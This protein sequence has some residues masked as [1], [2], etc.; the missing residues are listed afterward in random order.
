MHSVHSI[1]LLCTLLLTAL[2]NARRDDRTHGSAFPRRS[3]PLWG[4]TLSLLSL[5][6]VETLK[7]IG[8]FTHGQ[9]SFER[10]H[11][12]SAVAQQHHH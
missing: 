1:V 10:S 2:Q 5:Q 9:L 6:T 12:S 11:V 3:C 7:Y 8:I 4:S